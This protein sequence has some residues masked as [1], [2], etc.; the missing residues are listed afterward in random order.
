MSHFCSNSYTP[1][2]S[3]ILDSAL[4]TILIVTKLPPITMCN[5]GTGRSRWLSPLVLVMKPRITNT[6]S[7]SQIKS[8]M[9]TAHVYAANSSPGPLI[10][11][12]QKPTQE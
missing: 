1:N 3:T 9:N 4:D 11:G 2:G 5:S 12:P 10:P 8:F 7:Y 6:Y